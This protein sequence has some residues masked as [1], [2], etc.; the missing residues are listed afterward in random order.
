MNNT[1]Q[2]Q[3]FNSDGVPL[4]NLS[5]DIGI[6]YGCGG[7]LADGWH[8]LTFNES[9]GK[10]V[11]NTVPI[12]Q[13]LVRGVASGDTTYKT[14]G[15]V[16]GSNSSLEM[17]VYPTFGTISSDGCGIISGTGNYIVSETIVNN[18]TPTFLID[19]ISITFEDGPCWGCENAYLEKIM[20]GPLT[21]WDYTTVGTRVGS[22]TQVILD[23]VLYAYNGNTTIDFYFNNSPTGSGNPIDMSATP[24]TLKFYPTNAPSQQISFEA[25][26]TSCTIPALTF[27]GGTAVLS[28]ADNQ[29]VTFEVANSG[30]FPLTF[31]AVS[32][33]NLTWQSPGIGNCWQCEYPYLSTI[34]SGGQQYWSYSNEGGGTRASSSSNLFLRNTLYI[35]GASNTSIELTFNNQPTGT[36]GDIDMS[37]VDFNIPFNSNCDAFGPT[38]SVSFT[39]TGGAQTCSACA[40]SYS[41]SSIFGT[42][43]P[44]NLQLDLINAGV[45]CTITAITITSSLTT[46]GYQPVVFRIRDNNA[47]KWH[48]VSDNGSIRASTVAP[49]TTMILTETLTLTQADAIIDQIE[50]ERPDY[51]T[52]NMAGAS[53]TISLTMGCCD[54]I[55]PQN[56]SFTIP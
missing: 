26:G 15:V 18:G 43:R 46:S 11:I 19:K 14:L 48:C 40:T 23:Q 50:F 13:R 35:P 1:V 12:G 22:G 30:A 54:C 42:P 17:T 21:Y 47:D 31:D 38:Q 20:V 36:G 37:N 7:P 2:V 6:Q 34:E 25:C 52:I 55:S 3:L 4:D 27:V 8:P 29:I 33:L 32:I 44:S 39:A 45:P 28:G 56:Y 53:L 49:G 9:T 10:F 41:G 24:M 5:G 51:S 16:P